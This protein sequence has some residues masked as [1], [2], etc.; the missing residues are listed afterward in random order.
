M[1]CTDLLSDAEFWDQLR[2]LQGTMTAAQYVHKMQYCFN[3]IVELPLS[4]GKTIERFMAGLNPALKK[5]VVTAPIG[6]GRNDKWIDPA[7]LMS[8]AVMQAQALVNGGGSTTAGAGPSSSSA[9]GPASLGQKRARD[10]QG[11]GKANKKHKGKGKQS[12]TGQSD[13]PA[14]RTAAEK[15]WLTKSKLCF[16]C[17]KPGHALYDCEAKKSDKPFSPMP[18]AFAKSAKA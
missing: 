12:G 13:R 15:A 9:A 7:K 16:H 10:G 8:Y 11:K 6:M 3:G 1:K 2:D 17:V 14:F 4:D 5:L 18:Q